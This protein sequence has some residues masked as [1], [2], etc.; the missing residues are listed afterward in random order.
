MTTGGAG[1]SSNGVTVAVVAR[2]GGVLVND[3]LAN[4]DDSVLLPSMLPPEV[5]A[6]KPDP[7]AD[8][9]TVRVLLL[10]DV[11]AALTISECLHKKWSASSARRRL[12]ASTTLH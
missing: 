6:A 9:T 4:V 1:G 8:V 11:G 7:E 5:A 12:S 10:G 3:W 2:S